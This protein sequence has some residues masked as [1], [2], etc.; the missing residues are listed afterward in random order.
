MGAGLRNRLH[1]ACVATEPI[2]QGEDYVVGAQYRDV[3]TGSTTRHNSAE[4]ML[5]KLHKEIADSVLMGSDRY[6]DYDDSDDL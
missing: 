2:P 5:L 4:V 3:N 6:R 1:T